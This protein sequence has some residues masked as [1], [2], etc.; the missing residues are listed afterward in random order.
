MVNKKLLFSLVLMVSVLSLASAG[1]F[2]YFTDTQTTKS[3]AITA[4][5][6]TLN[7]GIKDV[8]LIVPNAIPSDNNKAFGTPFAV[9]N[10]G[11]TSGVLSATLTG[12]TGA[13]DFGNDLEID[14]LKADG[15]TWTP[16]YQNG[17]VVPVTL[18]SNFANGAAFNE[19]F[20]YTYTK[21]TQVQTQGKTFGFNIQYE[22]RQA[23]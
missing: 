5:T 7:E 18:S 8:Q 23:P 1:T 17:A 15:V 22:L 20:R 10:T 4:G 11:T 13:A 3:N 6:L 21:T 9:T 12:V 14:I 2:A 19:Y 16:I